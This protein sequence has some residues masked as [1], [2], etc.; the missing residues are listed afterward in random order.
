MS[1]SNES[2]TS[3]LINEQLRKRFENHNS[4]KVT[5]LDAQSCIAV[6]IPTGKNVT[7]EGEAGD[8]FAGL[9][10]GSKIILN[11]DAGRFTGNGMLEGEVIIN[12]SC[13]EGIGHCLSGGVII[14]HGSVE[15]DACISVKGGKI[16]IAGSVQG[17]IATCMTGG[18]LIVCGD[19]LGNIGKMM[20]GGKIFLA[21]EFDLNDSIE[22][23][24]ISPSDW[25]SIKKVLLDNGIDSKGLKFKTVKSKSK[26]TAK[27]SKEYS[28]VSI[29]ESIAFVPA[30]LNK[31]PRTPNLDNLELTLSIGKN[32]TEPLNMTIPL[33]WRGR[34][35][36]TYAEWPLNSSGPDNLDVANLAIID[37]TAT[38]INRRLD[39]KKP[40][41]LAFIVELLRQATAKRIPILVKLNAGDIHNDLSVVNKC[42]ADGVILVGD[43]IPIE[44]VAS[45]ARKYK[46]DMVV[47]ISCK[48]LDCEQI[49]KIISLGA[50]GIFIDGNYSNKELKELGTD[51]ANLVGN[52]GV[53]NI[54]DLR[55]EHLRTTNQ[56]TAAITGIPLA[57]YNSVLPLWR[58]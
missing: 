21:G 47:L 28:Q 32:K 46:E 30:V 52:L 36:P 35:A 50:S 6:N 13:K 53:G 38:D 55:A 12:G 33:L 11:G 16:V 18:N 44:S 57:G 5:N 41:D 43:K 31:R 54:N 14:I 9:N 29:S 25:K 34:N 39:M 7:F 40:K 51:I 20:T 42:S 8:N 23:Q 19:V 3:S 10:N 1:N 56:D 58:H 17:D 27:K 26:Q 37:L 45:A 22:V 2:W 48:M 24:N 4:A 15:G 49:V